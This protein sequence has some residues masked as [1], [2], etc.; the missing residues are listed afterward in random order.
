MQISQAKFCLGL[1][2]ENR[3]HFRIFIHVRAETLIAIYMSTTY[4]LRSVT[5]E[6]TEFFWQS[7]LQKTTS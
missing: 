1:T 2:T 7:G 3:L 6:S 5:V 4:Y